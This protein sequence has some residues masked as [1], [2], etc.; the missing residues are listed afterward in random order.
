M[1]LYIRSAEV[2]RLARML[3]DRTGES[4]TDAVGRALDERLQRLGPQEPSASERERRRQIH[5]LCGR[6]RELAVRSGFEPPGKREIEE[7][8]GF[9]EY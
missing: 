5:E 4:I 3:A 2:D 7:M 8:L 1:V 9:N 6:T